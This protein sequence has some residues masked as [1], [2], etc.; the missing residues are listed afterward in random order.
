VPNI[1]FDVG[2]SQWF[3]ATLSD[4]TPVTAGMEIPYTDGTETPVTVGTETPYAVGIE[5]SYS[6]DLYKLL[7]VFV[8]YY[9]SQ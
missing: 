2:G 4:F 7:S 6:F 5:T 8:C 3:T 9:L 1:Y